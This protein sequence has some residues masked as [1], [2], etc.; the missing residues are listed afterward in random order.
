MDIIGS[1]QSARAQLLSFLQQKKSADSY[2]LN[3][4]YDLGPGKHCY[5]SRL[6]HYMRYQ[7]ITEEQVVEA[8]LKH[9]DPASQ[10]CFL[11][12]VL[13]RTYWKGFLEL[14]PSIWMDY[15]RACK[16][17]LEPGTAKILLRVRQGSVGIGAFDFWTRE[18]METGY[19]HNHTR[20]WYASIWIFTLQ[21]PWY[22]GAQF[23]LEFLTDGDPCVNT[24]SWRWVAG[25]HT[26][27][28]AYL[29]R[30]ENIAKFTLNRLAPEGLSQSFLPITEEHEHTIV[31]IKMLSNKATKKT[32]DA[33]LLTIDD[34]TAFDQISVSDI[35]ASCLYL[36]TLPSKSSQLVR[37]FREEAIEDTKLFYKAKG[38]NVIQISNIDD[39]PKNQSILGFLPAIGFDRD[40]IEKSTN[41]NSIEWLRRSWDTSLWPFATAGFFRFYRKI[42]SKL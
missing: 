28:K 19:L 1:R 14:R 12:E 25:L 18:L 13:W 7:L 23:F 32:Y 30:T 16:Q 38:L 40:H 41:K 31:P 22:L 20:M 21:L 33:I 5:V 26:K 9:S 8:C 3:R 27:G 15:L 36:L 17:P 29:A 34:C 10:E 11:K 4:N 37:L 24:L 6:S 2:T 35:R 42:Q 39:L